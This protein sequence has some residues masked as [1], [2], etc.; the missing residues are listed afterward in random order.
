LGKRLVPIAGLAVGA[1]VVGFDE[2][3]AVGAAVV[4]FDGHGGG[5]DVW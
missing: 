2:G 3:L 5:E 4:G 1:A